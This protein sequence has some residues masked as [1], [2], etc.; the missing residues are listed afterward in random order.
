MGR[1][2]RLSVVRLFVICHCKGV[3]LLTFCSAPC[4]FL[5]QFSSETKMNEPFSRPRVTRAIRNIVDFLRHAAPN[6]AAVRS[7][8]IACLTTLC[9]ATQDFSFRL[10]SMYYEEWTCIVQL[11]PELRDLVTTLMSAV[12][13]RRDHDTTR[14]LLQRLLATVLD[15]VVPE[16][17][18][19][20][21]KAPVAFVTIVGANSA[22]GS[23]VSSIA[24]NATSTRTDPSIGVDDSD[25]DTNANTN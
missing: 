2:C 6:D 8:M 22:E 4:F 7:F 13:P 16:Q 18:P 21:H 3:D 1:G 5:T 19:V 15:P 20:P 10:L 17:A 14:E 11:P 24:S 23:R 25:T 12:A 9:W